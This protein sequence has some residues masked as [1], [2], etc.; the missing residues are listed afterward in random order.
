MEDPDVMWAE[1]ID[2]REYRVLPVFLQH[3][4]GM[5]CTDSG[6]FPSAPSEGDRKSSWGIPP[7]VYGLYPYYINRFVKETG[8]LSLEE[9]IRK[10][11][12][13]PAQDVLG[14]KD[15]GV[16]EQGTYAD[17]VIFDFERIREGADFLEPTR[18]PEGINYVLVNGTVVCE[19]AKHTNA[20]PG[21]VLRHTAR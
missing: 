16:I 11:T 12:S 2:K 7:I 9:A 1:F 5:P 10:A 15:R 18:P 20:H 17:I 8:V 13:M 19:N 4:V 21:K 6:F 3:P 14:L